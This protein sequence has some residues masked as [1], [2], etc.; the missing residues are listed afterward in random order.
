MSVNSFEQSTLRI[1]LSMPTRA[2]RTCVRS[3]DGGPMHPEEMA[4]RKDRMDLE[5]F[6]DLLPRHHYQL[7]PFEICRT[8]INH[9]E[10]IK[11]YLSIVAK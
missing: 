3:G 5:I 6:P 2:R 8:C 11:S 1:F 4:S 9:I 7:N 10:R